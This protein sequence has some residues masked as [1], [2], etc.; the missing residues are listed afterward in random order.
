MRKY[1]D[2]ALFFCSLFFFWLYSPHFLCY[3]LLGKQRRLLI[4][5]D[6]KCLLPKIYISLPV[7]AGLLFFL[8]NNSY[9]RTLF[10]YRIGPIA[11][12]LI[13]WYRPGNKYFI[14]SKTMK[15]G[16]GF[17]LAHPYSTIL[18]ADSIGNNFSCRHCTTLGAKENGRPV[19]GDNVSLG[20]GVI[21]IGH[22]RIGS[23]VIVGAR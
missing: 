1:R 23:N 6:V 2:V 11:S 13:G 5:S 22:I 14:I 18:N 8:H 3:Y 9:F 15:L 12:L 16:G 17:L 7:L 21:I 10:Y 4:N 20:A 19:I